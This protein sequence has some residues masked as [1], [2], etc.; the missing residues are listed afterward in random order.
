[1]TDDSSPIRIAVIGSG[2]AGFYAAGHL[3][4]DSS[5]R[6]EVDMIERLPTPW[7]LVRSG[8][9]PDHPKIKSVT[10]V[11]EKTAAH[12]RFRYF[13]NVSFGE[14]VSREDLLARYHA[15]VYATGSPLDRPLRIPGEQLPGSHA[16]TEFVGWYNG[17]P[18]HS[19]LEVD[20]VSA[21]RAIVI[22]NGNVAIDVARMLMLSA[23]ELAPTDTADHALEVLA[24]SRVHE[25]L[26]VGRRGP[27]QAAFTNPELLELDEL[28]GADVLVDKN[29]LERALASRDETAE[30]DA[31]ARRN[32]EI[33]RR[34]AEH[35]P[36]P[37]R[38]RIVLRFLLSPVELIAGE[39]GALAAV[40]LVRNELVPGDDGALKAR[41]TDESE[42]IAA[43]LA[44]RAIGY[45]GV[46]LPGVS[47]DERAATI[48]NARGRVLDPEGREPLPG[49]Y[50]VGWIKRGPSGVIGT[51]KKDAQ[52][53][54]DAMLA[55]LRPSANGD[56]AGVDATPAGAGA[57]H[58]PSEPDASA[59]EA[60]LRERQPA[61]VTYS[62]WEAID[63]HERALGEPDGR[64]RV[65]L[66]EIEEMLRIAAAE[67]PSSD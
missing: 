19:G 63:R 20:L 10:R 51:N 33:L 50:V 47:F 52:E 49:E 13:G 16:A 23:K 61:L 43:G 59:V 22:G 14:H 8:V 44:F 48:L 58:T 6:I 21:E 2:P 53:T 54:V 42:A 30:Q 17:H 1:M 29:E 41:A 56:R 25:V 38:K 3:L 11:Y 15:I 57:P 62:G 45:R 65:K 7:G 66:T 39:D 36:T 26:V 32:V 60:L 9:A 31:T 64:P 5:E 28:S 35:A 40:K 67:S 27:A 4:K 46:P 37:G 24:R 55:D 34:Y 18:D 12:P